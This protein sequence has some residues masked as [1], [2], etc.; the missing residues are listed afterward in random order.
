MRDLSELDLEWRISLAKDGDGGPLA[1]RLLSDAYPITS[2]LRKFLAGVVTGKIKLKRPRK[3]TYESREQRHWRERKVVWMVNY[4]MR[5]AGKQRDK[6]LRT[7]PIRK[8]CEKFGTKPNI[9][10]DYRKRNRRRPTD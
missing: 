2:S 7:F 4:E 8:W 3:L 6:K 9:V 10:A 5:Q 1:K